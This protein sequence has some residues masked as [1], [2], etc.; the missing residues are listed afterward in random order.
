MLF[1]A[2]IE[3]SSIPISKPT[4][5]KRYFSTFLPV[6]RKILSG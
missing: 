4:L 6:F 5:I 2:C 1:I 3:T